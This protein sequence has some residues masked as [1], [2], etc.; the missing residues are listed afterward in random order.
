MTEP[1]YSRRDFLVGVLATGTLAA[2]GTYL[3][4]G[5]RSEPAI[6]LRFVTGAD[7]TGARDL[8]VSMWNRANP[9]AFVLTDELPDSAAD[10]HD[11]MI[12]KAENK[13]ADVLNLDIVDVPYFHQRGFI[14]PIELQDAQEFVDTTLLASRLGDP[15]ATEFWAAPFN[16]DAGMLFERLGTD[17]APAG[18]TDTPQLKA[19][20][21]GLARDRSKQ[22]AG[23]LKPE[24]ESSYEAFTVNI[25][26]H[27][28]SRNPDLL[29][30][31]KGTPAWDLD[32]WRNALQPLRDAVVAERVTLC[33]SEVDT[34]QKFL[35]PPPLTYMRNWPVKYRELQQAGDPDVARGRIRVGP[36]GVGILGGQSLAVVRT[37]PNA[38]RAADFIRFLTSESAQKILASY[39]LAPTR[40]GAYNDTSLKAFIPHLQKIRG[41]VE[42]ARPRPIHPSYAAFSAALVPPVRR[43]LDDGQELSKQFID[44]LEKAL[45]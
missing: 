44:D 24:S 36:L 10:A 8:L 37:S 17:P 22:F 41:A 34:R 18:D 19:V 7:P 42:Q 20:V 15:K 13:A 6:T 33:S 31:G 12:S 35:G 11:T 29:D 28:L 3:A 40:K 38:S 23:Q 26:E 45:P 30:A 1:R 9:R 21:D 32:A 16:A 2:V 43:L 14:A 39:G 25:L 5:G 4:P 27:A